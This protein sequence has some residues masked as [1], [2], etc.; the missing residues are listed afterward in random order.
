MAEKQDREE[1]RA[2]RRLEAGASIVGA[3]LALGT[4]GI[5]LWDGIRASDTPP[6]VVVEALS[7]LEREN[8]FLMEVLASNLGG[9][10]A[11]GILVEGELRQGSKVIATSEATFDYVPGHSSREGGLFFAED[12]RSYEVQLRALG[13]ID[14]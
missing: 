10:T 13:Y 12:P 6:F 2:K 11:A 9:R 7:V 1:S 5:V 4:I 14:P 3:V 8:G